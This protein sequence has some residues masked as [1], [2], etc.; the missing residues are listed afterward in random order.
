MARL[1]VMHLNGP[2]SLNLRDILIPCCERKSGWYDFGIGKPSRFI[3][4]ILAITE[5]ILFAFQKIHTEII[6]K[7]ENLSNFVL[8][9]HSSPPVNLAITLH[10]FTNFSQKNSKKA[11]CQNP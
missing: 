3:A 2:Q 7:I 1:S 11:L 5:L 8:G 10:K 4:M 6:G 9:N